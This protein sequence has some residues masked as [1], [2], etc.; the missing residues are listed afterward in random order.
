MS[1]TQKE[2]GAKR[3][4]NPKRVVKRN[5]RSTATQEDRRDLRDARRAIEEAKQKGTVSWEEMKQELDL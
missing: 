4:A 5:A 3:R 2:T 1:S